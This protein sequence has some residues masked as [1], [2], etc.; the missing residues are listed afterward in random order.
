MR[1]EDTWWFKENVELPSDFT[2][3]FETHGGTHFLG[4]YY[5]GSEQEQFV[6]ATTSFVRLAV[7]YL[8]QA[9]VLKEIKFLPETEREAII[10]ARVGQGRYRENL[11]RIESECRITGVSE[12]SLLRASHMMLW[13][14]CKDATERLDGNNGLLLTPTY[15]VMFDRGY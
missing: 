13:S 2:P 15:D 7:A 11:L 8:L 12:P 9:T 14:L 4:I 10:R 6:H 1:W 3:V 5:F